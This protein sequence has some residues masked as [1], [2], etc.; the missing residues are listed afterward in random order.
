MCVMRRLNGCTFLMESPLIANSAEISRIG[1]GV[2]IAKIERKEKITSALIIY[3]I[4][5]RAV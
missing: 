2:K 1:D 5:C 4:F 3:K